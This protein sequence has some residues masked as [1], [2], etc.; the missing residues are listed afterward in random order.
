MS[1]VLLAITQEEFRDI[2]K[3]H[4]I[5]MKLYEELVLAWMPSF[6]ANRCHVCCWL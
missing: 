5:V 6:N 2:D 4:A 3:A 1:L